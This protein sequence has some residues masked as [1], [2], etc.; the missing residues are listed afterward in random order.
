MITLSHD[1]IKII[2]KVSDGGIQL[3][4]GCAG[5][6]KSY[7]I[8]KISEKYYKDYSFIFLGST[9]KA[10]TVLK[11][12][13]ISYATTYHKLLKYIPQYSEDGN[14]YLEPDKDRWNARSIFKNIKNPV[15]MIID[16]CSMINK[17]D[18]V[19]ILD[20]YNQFK[21]IIYCMIFVGDPCQLPPI[22]KDDNGS[23]IIEKESR[24]FSIRNKDELTTI[25]RT[26]DKDIALLYKIFRE[27]ICVNDFSLVNKAL[28]YI[29]LKPESNVKI[30]SKQAYF[31]N[32]YIADKEENKY[33]I[34]CSNKQVQYYNK[35]IRNKLFNNTENKYEVGEKLMFNSYYKFN[36]DYTFYT[37]DLIAITH[38]EILENEFRVGV[39]TIKKYKYYKM[40]GKRLNNDYDTTSVE[41]FYVCKPYSDKDKEIFYRFMKYE[42]DK[43]FANN[44]KLKATLW[45]EF[46]ETKNRYNS[47]VIYGYALTTYKAQG[48]EYD[49]IYIDMN[50]ILRCRQMNELQLGKELYTAITRSKKKLNIYYT[51]P[52]EYISKPI[53]T[54]NDTKKKCIFCKKNK[55]IKE[56]INKNDKENKYC[57]VCSDYQSNR[58]KIKLKKEKERINSPK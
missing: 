46:Y 50:N 39:N 7:A 48:D 8:K 22:L 19:H 35:I 24:T 12:K 20:F 6:G 57:N 32:K 4:M 2:N 23:I 26:N 52:D 18:C 33:I 31:I 1:Q 37:C 36:S 43:I 15:I 21:K 3:I 30:Y 54:N 58:R 56:F 53:V 47:P 49:H 9:N 13:G 55:L 17:I 16:E 27:F 14:K 34:A 45:H 28:S 41:P 29:H 44:T 25:F 51:I 10:V 38:I 42:K 40:T 5:S 11:K